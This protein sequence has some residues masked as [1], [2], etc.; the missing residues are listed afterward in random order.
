MPETYDVVVA[1]GGHNGLIAA[2][3]LAKAGV[4]VCVVECSEKLGGSVM[5]SELTAPGFKHDVCSVAHTMIQANPL[6]QHDELELKS[7]FG[8]QYVNPQKMTAAFFDDGSVLEFWT[9]LDR[10]CESIAQF[11]QRDA[12]NYR[13]FVETVF[14]TLDMLVMGMFNVPP[15]M[16]SLA[17]VLD[18]SP[19]GRELMRTQAISSWDVIDEWF[20]NDKVKIALARYASE[21]MTNPFDYGTGFGFY[22]ILPYMYRYGTGIPIGGSGALVEA[23]TRCLDSHGGT[24]KVSS[25][26]KQFKLSGHEVAGLVLEDGEEILARRGV[27]STL[28]A[29]QVFPH[30]VPGAKLP[31]GFERGVQVAKSAAFQPF[32]VHVALHE[33]LSYKAGDGLDDFFWVEKSHADVEEFA[34]AFRDLQHGYPRRDF[35]AYVAPQNVDP[36]R[37]PDGKHMLHLYA[38]APYDLKDG[39]PQKW[40]Q[41]GQEVA[42]GFL[43]DLRQLTTNLDDDNII[44]RTH[45]TPLDFERHNR[46][47]VKADIGHLG[48]YAWQLSGNRP[49]PGWG[50]Y[51]TPLGKLY[52][53]GASTHPGGG[54]TGGSGRNVA[55]VV[56]EDLKVDG[57]PPEPAGVRRRRRH[58]RVS[59]QGRP[60]ANGGP[61]QPIPENAGGM[62]MYDKD[63][64]EMMDIQSIDRDGDDLVVNGKMMGSMSAQ[65]YVRAEEIWKARKLMSPSLLASMPLML[66]KSSRR[67]RRP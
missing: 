36:S 59:P 30:M 65:I 29:K 8:L 18:Q 9:D 7:K 27:I 63:G 14:Q 58:L 37:V 62:K 32:C 28:N 52:L 47:L 12:H 33:R 38:F 11:S 39:G 46:A 1:G 61:Q 3:Y 43:D 19:E 6:I 53:A 35:A 49:V 51:R 50:Q 48:L 34:K 10:T 13:R 5:T 24:Y 54:V 26:I 66:L 21:A 64:N 17:A 42:D 23:L 57:H 4:D 31:A 44:G 22:I 41:I 2:C 55:Q 60:N 45:M 25:P 56:M 40:D 67:G 16:G 20:E 15:G